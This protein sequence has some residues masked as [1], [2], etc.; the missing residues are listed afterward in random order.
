MAREAFICKEANVDGRV[1]TNIRPVYGLQPRKSQ[2]LFAFLHQVYWFHLIARNDDTA[3]VDGEEIKDNWEFDFI[4]KTKLWWSKNV[5]EEQKS[6]EQIIIGAGDWKFCSLIGLAIHLERWI[7]SGEGLVNDLIFGMEGD[8][9]KNAK[10]NVWKY[11][12]SYIDSNEFHALR[13]EPLGTHSIRKC[14]NTY[15]C[16]TGNSKDDNDYWARWKGKKRQGNT[17]EDTILP[18]PDAKV[19]VSLAIGGPIKYALW[20]GSGVDNNFI[21]THVVPNIRLRYGEGGCCVL[22]WALL[23]ACFDREAK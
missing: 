10:D 1:V 18:Y 4:L 17:Y 21:F 12:K 23:W 15:S 7:G 6:P 3:D 8:N 16:W 14:A 13:S 5:H 9:P 2:V 22:R 20:Q 19:A 11:L